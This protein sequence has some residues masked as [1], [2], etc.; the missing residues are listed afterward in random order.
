MANPNTLYLYTD[1][2]KINKSGF[3]RVGAATVAY[4][5][6]N[7]IETGKMGLG[8]HAE[9]FDAEMAALSLAASKA[10]DFHR[11]FLNITHITIFSDSAASIKAITDPQPSSAQYYML[12]FHNYIR[13][14][15]TNN[16]N[17]SIAVSWCPSHCD[18]LGNERADELAKEATS[19]ESQASFSTTQSNTK[20]RSKR[21]ALLLWQQEWKA[22][23]KYGRFAIANRIPPSLKPTKHFL[24]LKRSHEVLGRVLQ[25]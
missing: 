3:Y 7:E 24:A 23:P 18:I 21:A 1:S 5:Q 13:P 25:C 10:S 12:S 14:L 9:V 6:G 22:T 11:D 2:S 15:L 19:L 16:A 20:R 8:G 4:F 17:L